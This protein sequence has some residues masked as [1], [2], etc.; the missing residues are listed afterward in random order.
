MEKKKPG[1]LSDS[2]IDDCFDSLS[3]S[4]FSSSDPTQKSDDTP[5]QRIPHVQYHSYHSVHQLEPS[6]I[7][8]IITHNS[9]EE[10][11]EDQKENLF[12][13]STQDYSMWT[14]PFSTSIAACDILQAFRKKKSRKNS[15]RVTF[16]LTKKT[17]DDSQSENAP[18]SSKAASLEVQSELNRP[19]LLGSKRAANIEMK[20]QNRLR[21]NSEDKSAFLRDPRGHEILNMLRNQDEDEISSQLLFN[22]VITLEDYLE[23]FL[24]GDFE[25]NDGNFQELFEILGFLGRAGCPYTSHK[26]VCLMQRVLSHKQKRGNIR[27][28]QAN[29]LKKW[30]L[31]IPEYKKPATATTLKEYREWKNNYHFRLQAD[32]IR[33]ALGTNTYPTPQQIHREVEYTTLMLRNAKLEYFS[34]YFSSMTTGLKTWVDELIETNK[35]LKSQIKESETIKT[36]ETRKQAENRLQELLVPASNEQID[37]ARSQSSP[38]DSSEWKQS[39]RHRLHILGRN[40]HKIKTRKAP[41]LETKTELDSAV[42]LP[43]AASVV[44]P[45]H[46]VQQERPTGADI[47]ESAADG[48]IRNVE[49]STW[50]HE[51]LATDNAGEFEEHQ[52]DQLDKMSKT[53]LEHSSRARTNSK[54]STSSSEITIKEFSESVRNRAQAAGLLPGQQEA[55]DRLAA[56]QSESARLA[57]VLKEKHLLKEQQK[58]IDKIEA[59][60]NADAEKQRLLIETQGR[61]A[62]EKGKFEVA[63][64]KKTS[65]RRRKLGFMSS[66]GISGDSGVSGMSTRSSESKPLKQNAKSSQSRPR[67]ERVTSSESKPWNEPNRLNRSGYWTQSDK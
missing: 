66:R 58:V 44:T 25:P 22:R 38:C 63:T 48:W 49:E 5:R 55:L 51:M 37:D 39:L 35:D 12:W 53:L 14:K 2:G 20:A 65:G 52:A 36:N 28:K 21:A 50:R 27:V 46:A 13:W 40:A 24:E 60:A 10:P 6:L 33:P 47:L 7:G 18:E 16:D 4:N 1:D 23:K 56:E 61:I 3:G 19:G 11:S 64:K 9:V 34:M 17:R 59:E 57:E 15:S 42:T 8:G 32:H 26:I 45:A 54:D 67:K 41:L 29:D 30:S 43:E 62:I 31:V